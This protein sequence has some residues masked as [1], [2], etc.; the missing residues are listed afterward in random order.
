MSFGIH[1]GHI[2]CTVFNSDFSDES[3]L[4]NRLFCNSFWSVFTNY[5][6]LSLRCRRTE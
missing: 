4:T 6:G 3:T 2:D 1:S 5:F